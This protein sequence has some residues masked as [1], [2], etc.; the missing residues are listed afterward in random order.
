MWIQILDEQ[1]DEVFSFNK[2]KNIPKH[3]ILGEL[4]SDYM[5]PAKKVI[6]YLRGMKRKT[7][8]I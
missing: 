6:N 7:I 1:G 8:R 5:Y 2:P 3:Y 4:I